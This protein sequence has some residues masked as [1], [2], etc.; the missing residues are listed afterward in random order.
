M[1]GNSLCI[2]N[3]EFIC[4]NEKY[5]IDDLFTTEFYQWSDTQ[6]DKY[7]FDNIFDNVIYLNVLMNVL[8]IRFFIRIKNICEITVQSADS[9]M[10]CY[11]VDAAAIENI[12][13]KY[14][15]TK[16]FRMSAIKNKAIIV[17]ESFY[18]A[19]N[20]LKIR[21]E[22]REIDLNKDFCVLRTVAAKKKILPSMDREIFVENGVGKGNLYSFLGL[23]KRLKLL[24]KARQNTFVSFCN[25]RDMLN[26]HQLYR[27]KSVA[28]DFIKYRIVPAEFYG[29]II[30][31]IM[32]LPWRGRFISGNNLDMYACIEE[33]M[34]RKHAMG[35]VCIPHGLEY[36]YKFPHGFTGDLFYATSVKA[37]KWLNGLYGTDK[38]VFDESVV[39][40]MFKISF[41][42]TNERRVVYF[43]E[44]REPYVNLNILRK[45]I[46]YLQKQDVTVFIKHH[47][48]DNFEDYDEFTNLPV[49]KD[50]KDAI[51]GN[52][53]VSRKSTVLLEGLYN[54][55]ACAAIITNEKDNAIF[56][57]F[58]SLCD[59][60]I[61]EFHDIEKLGE[62]IVC[63]LKDKK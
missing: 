16:L 2:I 18:L 30:D 25:L 32:N 55:A 42:K 24:R 26:K 45:L 29:L 8:A 44:P 1:N 12:R 17:A 5:L 9:K 56:H 13:I 14:N 48:G 3:N 49:I 43:S 11:I 19:L 63:Q 53:C 33:K 41:D 50:L 38:F 60:R 57:T 52:I 21:K 36:G 22:K 4:E 54:N 10:L 39:S 62:W 46:P 27:T 23:Q 35:T 58:P 59:E 40:S 15:K 28:F 20:Q 6:A 51:C 7:D 37:S 61:K 47:P 31:E 34:A